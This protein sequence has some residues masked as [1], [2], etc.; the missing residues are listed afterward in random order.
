[1][2]MGDHVCTFMVHLNCLN[3]TI[4][5]YIFS[6]QCYHISCKFRLR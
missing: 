5:V 4:C 3:V 1:M 2:P 6:F